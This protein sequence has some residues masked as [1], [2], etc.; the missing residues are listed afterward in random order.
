[1]SDEDNKE[2]SGELVK[3]R[4]LSL[5]KASLNLV[6]R[7][8]QDIERLN[9]PFI[10]S[11]GMKFVPV[12][13]TQALFSIW[14][15][16]VQDFEEFVKATR[17]VATAE[18]LSLS[19]EGGS[20]QNPGRYWKQRGHTWKN[21]GFPQGPTHPVRGVN[22]N[23]ATLFCKWLTRNEHME[24]LLAEGKEY[25]LPTDAEWSRAVGTAKY[26]WGNDWPPPQGAGNYAGEEAKNADWP[27]IYPTIEGYN[28]GYARTAPVGS[29]RANKYGLFDM[30]GNVWVWCEDWY[31]DEMNS[32][33]TRKAFSELT[34]DKVFRV[35]RGAGWNE[36][37]PEYLGVGY[38]NRN[39]PWNRSSDLG[40]RC[41]V[42]PSS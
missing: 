4:P 18:M 42:V 35:C 19:S 41:V 39:A 8:I 26:P 28:D 10:N 6:R 1:M 16:R 23:D 15:T 31:R 13:D 24:G 7:A 5:Q 21:P 37:Y 11:L 33:E 27:E 32:E 29:F 36:W 30:G 38:R 17:H 34:E 25:R 40:F 9:R 14:Q 3:A 2:P 20:A 22:W 12:P